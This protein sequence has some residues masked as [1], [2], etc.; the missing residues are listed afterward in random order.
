MARIFVMNDNLTTRIE[1]T[2]DGD[3]NLMAFCVGCNRGVADALDLL[4]GE[5]SDSYEDAIEE[6]ASPHAYSCQNCADYACTI[7]TRHVRGHRCRKI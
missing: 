4:D 1:M 2:Y 3:G 6:I 5:R 7:L